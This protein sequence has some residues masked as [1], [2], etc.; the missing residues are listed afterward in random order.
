MG[1]KTARDCHKHAIRRARERYQAFFTYK[2]MED[3]GRL[4]QRQDRRAKHLW[5]ESQTRSHFLLDDQFI[6]VY[7]K[8]L[9]AITT[10]L[11]PESIWAYIGDF[12]QPLP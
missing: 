9:R 10:F 11:P 5:T 8:K 4:I 1:M 12:R 3:F 6:I 7:N 2:E